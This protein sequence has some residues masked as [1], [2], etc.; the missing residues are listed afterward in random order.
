VNN[1]K[2]E[3][4]GG[5]KERGLIIVLPLKIGAYKRE[6]AYLREGGM[7]GLNRGFTVY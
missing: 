3:V 4:E 5:L 2:G 1:N 6:G 7:G